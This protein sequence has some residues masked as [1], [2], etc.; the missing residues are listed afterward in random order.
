MCIVA[1]FALQLT[2][3][4]SRQTGVDIERL[5]I[6]DERRQAREALSPRQLRAH[7]HETLIA[8]PRPAPEAWGT[9]GWPEEADEADEL[10]GFRAR[11]PDSGGDG[12]APIGGKPEISRDEPRLSRD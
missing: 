8:V 5:F 3:L 6:W 10:P 11:G 4:V 7:P 1:V 2:Q 12:R 9:E